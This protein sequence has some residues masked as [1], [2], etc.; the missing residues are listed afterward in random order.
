[1]N[2]FMSLAETGSRSVQTIS[3]VNEKVC[4]PADLRQIVACSHMCSI[5]CD[6]LLFVLQIR[7]RIAFQMTVDI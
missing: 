3:C 7:Q 2:S 6:Y 1:M 4:R 5:V